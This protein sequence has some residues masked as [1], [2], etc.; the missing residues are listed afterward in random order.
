MVQRE[1]LLSFMGL[2]KLPLIQQKWIMAEKWLGRPQQKEE[3]P[4]WQKYHLLL[5]NGEG[6]GGSHLEFFISPKETWP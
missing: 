1:E 6:G 2:K 3:Q 4:Q 5:R